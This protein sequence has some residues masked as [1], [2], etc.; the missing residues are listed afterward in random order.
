M[1]DKSLYRSIAIVI[2]TAIGAG[3]FAL[4]YAFMKAGYFT[5]IFYLIALGIISLVL[6]KAYGEVVLR[7]NERSQIIGYVQ[8]YLGPWGRGISLISFLFGIT[9][10][11]IAYTIQIGRFLEI[12][13]GDRLGG[14]A[15][16][17]GLCF[18]GIAS[19]IIL[20]GL[21]LVARFEQYL[22]T[23]LILLVGF[24]ILVGLPKVNVS[25]LFTLD[26]TNLFLP[27]GVVLFALS[28]A[29]AIP[30]SIDALPDRK[31]LS[32]VLTIGLLVP[33]IVYTLFTLVVVG[34]SGGFTDEAAIPGL[35]PMLGQGI[36]AVGALLGIM[37]MTTAFLSLGLVIREIY[38]FDLK[39]PKFL[40]WLAGLT[41]PL[42]VYLF[43]L[44]S[45]ISII[46][47]VGGIMGGFDGILIILMWR[48]AKKYGNRQ[49]ECTIDIP[50]WLQ[51]VMILIFALGIVYELYFNVLN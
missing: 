35:T 18:Y 4:P 41:P 6:L 14:N 23:L 46:S 39:F 20:I 50:N 48:K 28:A 29:S 12:L 33:L 30:D 51:G 13:I 40:A 24:I 17:Y 22:V 32:K 25:N 38:Q 9:G 44:T 31:K 2:G 5:G 27:Y 15:F 10:A 16:I 49:P 19:L 34:I 26:A 37:T 3:I 1:K 43:H 11:L 36:V 42:V 45:F 21:R 8:R 47:L 7:T